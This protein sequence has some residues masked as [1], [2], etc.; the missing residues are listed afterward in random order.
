[1]TKTSK[2]T[3]SK[4]NA[5]KTIVIFDMDR[6]VTK[7]GTF[8]SYLLN[9][10]GEEPSKYLYVFSVLFRMA[11]YVLK[12]KTRKALKEYM[13][14]AFMA[15]MS[16]SEAA[17]A[18]EDFYTKLYKN[19][20]HKDALEAIKDHQK[21]GHVVGL[22]T[23]SM[24][25]YVERIVKD[26]KLDFMIASQSVWEDGVIVPF[27]KNDN[28][29]G[30]EKARRVQAFLAGQKCRQVW[31]YS[32]HHTDQPTFELADIKVA[33]NPTPKLKKIAKERGYQIKNWK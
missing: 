29:Y 9:L 14:Q 19:G 25:F 3:T 13:L 31:F 2:T 20:L 28:C 17:K 26:L 18:S 33:V 6:T 24:D 7:K 16:K 5:A 21:Q 10:A 11:L 15:R 27:I 1:M 8:S 4:T 23:A 32:D 30:A 22:A 12:L